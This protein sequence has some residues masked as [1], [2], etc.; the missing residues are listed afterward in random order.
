MIWTLVSCGSC[1]SDKLTINGEQRSRRES[2]PNR[3]AINR[4]C[5]K[6]SK[7]YVPVPAP[8]TSSMCRRCGAKGICESQAVF[9]Y[10]SCGWVGNADFNAA[11]NVDHRTCAHFSIDWVQKNPAAGAVVVR[12]SGG[13][14]PALLTQRRVRG[15]L[16]KIRAQPW[17]PS[18]ISP[19]S[20]MQAEHPVHNAAGG[21]AS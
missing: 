4:A 18:Y 14:K 7:F 21:A 17:A 6:T 3:A 9:R 1:N 20:Q 10:P 13:P 8:G 11:N 2:V 15:H 16:Q 19:I 12:W 5:A